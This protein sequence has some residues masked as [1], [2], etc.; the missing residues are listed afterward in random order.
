LDK[1]E[2]TYKIAVAI[3]VY[4]LSW[5][6]EGWSAWRLGGK[7]G[8]ALF[9]ISLLPTGFFALTWKERLGQFLRE[10][11]G[12][13]RFLLDRDLHRRLL[14]ERRSLMEELGALSRLTP[15]PASI[16]DTGERQ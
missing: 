15:E 16:R 4:P 3:L 2:A 11:R 14:D 1:S 5:I 8:L 6:I 9:V 13:L 10:A 7:W 12:F